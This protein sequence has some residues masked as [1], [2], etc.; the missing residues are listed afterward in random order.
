MLKGARVVFMLVLSTVGAGSVGAQD[1]AQLC[2]SAS[3]V[4]VGQWASYALSGPQDDGAQVRFAIVSS[5]RR[6]DSTF[7]WF[8]VKRSGATNPA[9]N[10][11]VQVLVPGFGAELVG[12]RAMAVQQGTQPAMRFPDEMVGMLGQQVGQ[13]TPALG[14]VLHCATARV[15][16]SESVV[17]PA[18]SVRALHV[19]DPDGT[20]AWRVANV[21]FGFV[22][23]RTKDGSVMTLASHGASATS[24]IVGMP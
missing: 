11:V 2:Q 23:I 16:G 18:G 13:S 10:G 1:L 5:E 12:I 15:V 4:T 17:T 24:S 19:T 20:E 7:Y 21:P 8:E 6:G 22:K 9:H 3:H 14:I